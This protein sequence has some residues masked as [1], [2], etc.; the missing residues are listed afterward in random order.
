MARRLLIFVAI[1][2]VIVGLGFV[3]SARSKQVREN[4]EPTKPSGPVPVAAVAVT[5]GTL[6]DK[7]T[8]SGTVRSPSSVMVVSK[9]MGTIEKKSF[10]KG[11][12][13]KKGDILYEIEKDTVLA[14]KKRAVSGMDAA[15]AALVQTE[16]AYKNAES[17]YERSKKLFQQGSI[18]RQMLD[19]AETSYRASK[20]ALD[21]A[22]AGLK[23]GEAALELADIALDDSTIRSPSDGKVT[24]DFDLELGCM[25]NMGTPVASVV[26]M[27]E[28]R[29]ELQIPETFL[30]KVRKGTRAYIVPEGYPGTINAEITLVNPQVNE[31]SRSAEVWAAF[32]TPVD[33]NGA[34]LVRPGQFCRVEVVIS[35][36]DGIIVPASAMV[37]QGN[38]ETVMAVESGKAKQLPVTTG[39]RTSREVV[40]LSGLNGGETVVSSGARLLMDGDAVQ[41]TDDDKSDS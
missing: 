36:Q 27:S 35:S 40:V 32:K 18:T 34:E 17:E 4:F 19:G 41:V 26:Q 15:K 24:E 20:A 22:D 10:R 7:M 12:A 5:K 39:L 31:R 21:A 9:A 29:A 38:L 11:D 33:E 2:V 23:N 30:S 14:N 28:L 3:L 8:F 37:K 13:V 1:M 6:E 25:V 16:A